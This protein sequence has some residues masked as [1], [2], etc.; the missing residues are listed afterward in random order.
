MP[1]DDPNADRLFVSELDSVGLVMAGANP[2]SD[3]LI[4]KRADPPSGW[5]KV[6]DRLAAFFTSSRSPEDLAKLRDDLPEWQLVLDP[7][8]DKKRNIANMIE[9]M[10]HLDFTRRADEMFAEGQITRSER[11]GLSG[12][13]G[14]ALEAFAATVAD[15]APALLER[16]PWMDAAPE[17]IA[18]AAT[19]AQPEGPVTLGDTPESDGQDPDKEGHEMP[20]ITLS[21]E[22]REALDDDAKAYVEQLEAKLAAET[23]PEPVPDPVEKALAGASPELV[24]LLKTERE[25]AEARVAKAEADA[26]EAL[27]K[28]QVEA[29]LRIAKEFVAKAE[30]Y[31]EFAKAADLGPVLQAVTEKA[32]AEIAEQLEGWIKAADAAIRTSGLY[33]V[34]GLDGNDNEGSATAIIAKKAEALRADD[35][36]LS[37]EQAE[38]R[39]MASDPK[40]AKRADDEE[41]ARSERAGR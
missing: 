35:P 27:E 33:D 23:T 31:G 34:F 24:A 26:A 28:A 20:D 2:E 37:K 15:R 1:H 6:R 14:D 13:I 18:A 25:A 5:E 32:G 7:D 11:I 39:V 30:P 36:K 38:A 29:D 3:I 16:D 19:T 17:E 4:T 40:L 10:I 41:R 8:F 21:D 12:A 9:A 22:A